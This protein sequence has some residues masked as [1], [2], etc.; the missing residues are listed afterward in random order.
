VSYIES[1]RYSGLLWSSLFRAVGGN[2]IQG[3]G[4][5]VKRMIYAAGHPQLALESVAIRLGR[6]RQGVRVARGYEG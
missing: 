1:L 5:H 3:R 6:Q 2:S 4:R